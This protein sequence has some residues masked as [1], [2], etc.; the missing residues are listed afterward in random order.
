MGSLD[1]GAL[2]FYI[3]SHSE[4]WLRIVRYCIRT[5]RLALDNQHVLH[6]ISFNF[7]DP[8]DVH[9]SGSNSTESF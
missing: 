1:R 8:Q 9:L 3:L 4:H 2:Q 5:H 7:Q 6:G